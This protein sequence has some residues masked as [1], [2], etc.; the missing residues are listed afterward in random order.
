MV[1]FTSEDLVIF[2]THLNKQISVRTALV[3]ALTLVRNSQT[4][5]VINSG[6]N[7]DLDFS[8]RFNS[9][10]PLAGLARSFDCFTSSTALG[11]GGGHREKTLLSDNLTRSRA[12][13]A[14]HGR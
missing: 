5:A 8:R 1:L 9:A 7:C 3:A 12:G 2:H 6:R 11:T 14:S 13:L 4:S 10:L